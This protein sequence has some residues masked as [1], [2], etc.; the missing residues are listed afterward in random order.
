MKYPVKSSHSGGEPQSEN[1]HYCTKMKK[2][3]LKY[4]LSI[5]I[6]TIQPNLPV[7]HTSRS[8]DPPP[9]PPNHNQVS[10][11][12]MFSPA[13]CNKTKTLGTMKQEWMRNHQIL[14]IPPLPTTIN[15]VLPSGKTAQT[16]LGN[17]AHLSW[18]TPGEETERKQTQSSYYMA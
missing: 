18:K 6:Q 2:V 1:Y 3:K 11:S 13:T 4:I 5:L 12:K 7:K 14:I 9:P 15:A 17:G 8:S 10:Q 16:I